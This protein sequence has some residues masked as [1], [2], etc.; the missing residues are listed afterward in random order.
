M[1][2]VMSLSAPP[3]AIF[4]ADPL[5]SDGAIIEAHKIGLKIPDELSILG[6]DDT[7]MRARGLSD[8][9]GRLPRLT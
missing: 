9:D 8:H 4:I 7:D 6:F 1:R 5:I 2:R 3:T